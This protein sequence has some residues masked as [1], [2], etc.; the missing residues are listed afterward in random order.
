[1]YAVSTWRAS[2]MSGLASPPPGPHPA[3]AGCH[4][5]QDTFGRNDRAVGGRVVRR[6]R[7]REQPLEV[8]GP[9]ALVQVVV[10]DEPASQ[11][12]RH[13]VDEDVVLGEP[14]AGRIEQ[15]RVI[16]EALGNDAVPGLGHDGIRGAHDVF[17]PQAR[18][19]DVTIAQEPQVRR[20]GARESQGVSRGDD[21]VV[22][23]GRQRG[24]VERRNA[25]APERRK[26]QA[27][28]GR[29]SEVCADILRVPR[30]MPCHEG[31]VFDRARPAFEA[32]PHRQAQGGVHSGVGGPNGGEHLRRLAHQIG[33]RF[34]DPV[35]GE[36]SHR[37][38]GDTGSCRGF[39]RK[40][41]HVA[42]HEAGPAC[43]EERCF[44][45]GPRAELAVER[46]RRLN[47]AGQIEVEA[48]LLDDPS[49]GVE[50]QHVGRHPQGH[51]EQPA[52]GCRPDDQVRS[53]AARA[54]L[55]DHFDHARRMA[56]SVTRYVEHQHRGRRCPAHAVPSGR[57]PAVCGS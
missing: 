12:T 44:V 29:H 34:V 19:I 48:V 27:C 15:G 24:E 43:A 6:G 23:Q 37:D 50:R 49:V 20:R 13:R 40:R 17:V 8:A 36:V 42:D 33:V 14:S 26:N 39:E 9:A 57:V 10:I 35:P 32:A 22:A 30:R 54:D 1:M 47:R 41:R 21:G 3:E 5:C 38:A 53:R 18:L 31:D 2:Y 56:E 4:E 46:P 25:E 55:I 11:E 28:A 7:L 51:V 16:G 52:G 45:V